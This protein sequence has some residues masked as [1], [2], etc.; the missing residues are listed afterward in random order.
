MEIRPIRTE[1]DYQMALREIET[2]MDAQ[3]G[4]PAEDRLDVLAT[5]V[6]A[7][8]DRITHYAKDNHG[9]EWFDLD[10]HRYYR[11]PSGR[12]FRTERDGQ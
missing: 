1:T 7:Y 10:D 8:E 3:P 11:T 5:L 2:L 12:L 4:T 6:K 9:A